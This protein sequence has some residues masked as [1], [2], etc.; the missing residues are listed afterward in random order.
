MEDNQIGRPRALFAVQAILAKLMYCPLLPTVSKATIAGIKAEKEGLK[1]SEKS[2]H[3][4]RDAAD[5]LIHKSD[6]AGKKA[7][8]KSSGFFSGIGNLFKG[9]MDYLGDVSASSDTGSHHEKKS[10]CT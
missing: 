8:D 3:A 9:R 10:P 4:V 5:K 2:D 6:K 7:D 1:A